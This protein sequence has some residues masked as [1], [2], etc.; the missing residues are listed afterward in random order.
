MFNG[1][2][3]NTGK[4]TNIKRNKKSIQIEIRINKKPTM[5]MQTGKRQDMGM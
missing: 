3:F 2:I 5:V 1:I 4:V